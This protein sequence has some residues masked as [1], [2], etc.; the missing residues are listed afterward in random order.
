MFCFVRSSDN[1]KKHPQRVSK[2][3]QR[4]LE[5]LHLNVQTWASRERGRRESGRDERIA[6]LDRIKATVRVCF[7]G[8]QGSWVND[9]L[10]SL[11]IQLSKQTRSIT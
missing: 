3:Q 9:V 2:D 1:N 10:Y 7:W 8:G 5:N 6:Q 11:Q 4:T